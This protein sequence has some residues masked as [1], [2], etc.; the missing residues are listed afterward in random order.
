MLLQNIM[1]H[2]DAD[3]VT[4]RWT[5]TQSNPFPDFSINRKCR[6]FG[7]LERWQ[8]EHTADVEWDVTLK[9]PHD[10]VGV[11][12]EKGYWDLFPDESESREMSHHVG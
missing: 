7:V 11:P 4:Y 3:I 12:M 1:C 6:D 10:V 8:R 5:E 2:A 9:K